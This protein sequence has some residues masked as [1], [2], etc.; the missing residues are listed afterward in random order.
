MADKISYSNVNY[1]NAEV[2]NKGED[3]ETFIEDYRPSGKVNYDLIITDQLLK[4]KNAFN[5]NDTER[6]ISC[7]NTLEILIYPSI[8][9]NTE[10]LEKRKKLDI[11]FKD[12]DDEEQLKIK[13]RIKFTLL[14]NA[15]SDIGILLG[16]KYTD[17][18]R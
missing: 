1:N 18:I 11:I 10:Y 13:I 8:K 5:N 17:H 14:L 3:E 12:I 9:S 7:V 6:L 16:A 2:E 4:I 15:L